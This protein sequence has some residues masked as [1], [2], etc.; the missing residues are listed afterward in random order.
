MQIRIPQPKIANPG[1]L[2]SQFSKWLEAGKPTNTAPGSD[3]ISALEAIDLYNKGAEAFYNLV[4]IDGAIS[5]VNPEE[6]YFFACL[7][8]KSAVEQLRS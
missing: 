7:F 4:A 1:D 8:S 6:K 2:S 5:P 3:V